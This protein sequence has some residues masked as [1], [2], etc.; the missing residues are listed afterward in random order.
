M[1]LRDVFATAAAVLFSLGG[2]AAIVLALSSWLGKVWAN[3]ILEREK[4][5]LAK[6][7][8]A[9]KRVYTEEIERVRAELQ[10]AAFEHQTRFSWYHQK[11]AEL[12]ANVYRLI[13]DV[14]EYV[15]EMVSPMQLGGDEPRRKHIDETI[16]TYNELAR[17]YFGKKI[18]LEREICEKIE[19]IL[20]IIKAAITD[21]RISQ[22]PG[23]KGKESIILWNKAYKSMLNEVPPLL[24][25]LEQ[26][27]REMLT[28]IGPAA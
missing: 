18:F 22:D 23:F 28:K 7:V 8:E 2:G 11:K 14:S 19:S 6:D 13:Q 20:S 16:T 4:A 17:E 25:D 15:K 12:I 26:A 21:W 24:S 9:A 5:A 3:R 10:R 1:T 27:F